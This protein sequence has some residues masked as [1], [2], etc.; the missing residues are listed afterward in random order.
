MRLK[1]GP[2]NVFRHNFLVFLLSGAR[3]A[4]VDTSAIRSALTVTRTKKNSQRAKKDPA[5]FNFHSLIIF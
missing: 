3:C 4:I 1:E 2:K 5:F